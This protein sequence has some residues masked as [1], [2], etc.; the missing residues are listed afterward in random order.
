M[1]RN[2][3]APN[4]HCSALFAAS[5]PNDDN[6]DSSRIAVATA[7]ASATSTTAAGFPRS[8]DATFWPATA[9]T[10]SDKN[11][12]AARRVWV[13]PRVH[14]A[15]FG[16]CLR[17]LALVGDAA[18]SPRFDTTKKISIANIPA[19]MVLSS[20]GFPSDAWDV[21]LAVQLWTLCRAEWLNG[22]SNSSSSSSNLLLAGYVRMLMQQNGYLNDIDTDNKSVD[23]SPDFVN[24]PPNSSTAPYAVRHWTAEERAP[25]MDHP[26]GRE[27]LTLND[28]QQES[29]RSKY[30]ALDDAT[31]RNMSWEQFSWAMEAVHSRA[32]CGI[33]QSTSTTSSLA[34]TVLPLLA[35]IAAA[36]VGYVYAT[37]NYISLQQQPPSETGLMALAAATA[38]VAA[39]SMLTGSS[40]AP[41]SAVL[42]P[43]V[44][45]ANHASTAD[46]EILFDPIQQCFTLSVGP[47]CLI[48]RMPNT[49][50]S[51]ATATGPTQLCINY[52]TKSD[53]EWMINY[54]FLPGVPIDSCDSGTKATEVRHRLAQ[55]FLMRNASTTS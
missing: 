16:G 28:R 35:P 42:L 49:T 3:S 47:N 27:L 7:A 18:S 4:H 5:S 50:A 45:S 31:K 29:W 14:L 55:V 24:R 38:A 36:A 26:T 33:G 13:D 6:E 25:L 37:T 40:G 10:P 52:G 15:L 34:A 21:D 2:R 43:V 53:R 8:N 46:S 39:G 1:L 32:F 17:G 20:V 9:S 41:N 48:G 30:G 44:D 12:G 23:C 11:S 51:D 22:N 19:S 54:G